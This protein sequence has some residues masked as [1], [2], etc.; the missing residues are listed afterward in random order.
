M[1]LAGADEAEGSLLWGSGLQG[2][3]VAQRAQVMVQRRYHSHGE[4]ARFR[5]CFAISG[6]VS[7]NKNLRMREALKCRV[8][9][10]EPP[11]RSWL[12]RWHV[13]NGMPACMKA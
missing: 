2:T 1:S 10:D 13:N 4:H 7:G 5:S 12:N 9:A 8:D 11:G 6:D 3:A